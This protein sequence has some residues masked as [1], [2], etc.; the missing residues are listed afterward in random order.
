[1]AKRLLRRALKGALATLDRRSGHPYAS[2][3]GVAT[4]P[5]GTPILL[6]SRLAEHTRNLELDA[7]ASLLIDGSDATGDPLAAGRVS[8]L[9]RVVPSSSGTA[10]RRYLA[11]H[12][13]AEG[14]AD[15]ADF[16]FFGL[17]VERAHYIGGFGRI[18]PLAG[19]D[20]LLD[21]T[22]AETLVAAE[23]SLCVDLNREAA[24]TIARLGARVSGGHK[25]EWRIIGIDPA[26]FDLLLERDARRCDFPARVRSAAEARS[27]IDAA[28]KESSDSVK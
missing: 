26:G 17:V 23:P 2:L 3:V 13:E 6:L 10:R 21:L 16:S 7:R 9:G 11:R 19:E 27:A 22:G 12:P 8:L 20:V 4:E 15:F 24:G 5:D 28:L 14:Y 18:C 1:M 25:G